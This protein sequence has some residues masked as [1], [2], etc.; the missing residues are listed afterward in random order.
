MDV[1]RVATANFAKVVPVLLTVNGLG[2]V[3]GA[4]M[5]CGPGPQTCSGSAAPGST[6]QFQ[7]SPSTTGGTIS[8]TGCTSAA[9]P[10]C[11][12]VV[13]TS[14]ISVQA[15]FAGG[16]TGG[17]SSFAL[18]LDVSGDG[19]VTATR[20]AT[21]YC[22]AAGGSGCDASIPQNTAVTLTAIPAS[23]S[24]VDFNSWLTGP[25]AGSTSTTCNFTMTGAKSG[26]ADF[27]GDDLTYDLTGAVSGN[28]SIT[29]GGLQCRLTGTASCTGPQAAAAH[30]TLTALPGAGSS[31][32]GWS[33][34]CTGTSQTCTVV[35]S[36]DQNVTASFSQPAALND[37]LTISITGAGQV[38]ASGGR[39]L[40]TVKKPGACTQRYSPGTAV[41]LK[42]VPAAGY[43]FTG[44]SGDCA[45]K[46][47][48]CALTM[49]SSHQVAATFVR[50]PIAIGKKATVAKV[51]TGYRVTLHFVAGTAGR[52][53]VVGKRSGTKPV[54]AAKTV[55]AGAGSIR[56]TV[57]TRGTYAFTLTLH[58]KGKAYAIRVRVKV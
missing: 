15:T 46:K 13:G 5:T 30:I 42:A 21:I 37:D 22:T 49:S 45:G 20:G 19:Y 27:N 29:G 1:D 50:A 24:A 33:G 57:K 51:A 32:L 6:I 4:G 28:G 3:S 54:T 16:T 7:A 41:T 14:P 39:C 55:K 43:V 34:G 36:S 9:G 53:T 35:M 17:G 8:W 26:S 47:A 52:L 25:C 58:V 31:F 10:I 40:S 12:V 18:H 56:L 2:T 48:T 38:D 23:G 11:N 44:W